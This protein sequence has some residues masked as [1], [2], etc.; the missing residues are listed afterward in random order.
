[1]QCITVPSSASNIDNLSE[2]RIIER[3]KDHKRVSRGLPSCLKGERDDVECE[4]KSQTLP[5]IYIDDTSHEGNF[6]NF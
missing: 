5:R 2:N 6:N 3:D 4:F 1:M